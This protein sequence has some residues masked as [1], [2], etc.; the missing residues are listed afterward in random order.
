MK[1]VTEDFKK[2]S[3][4]KNKDC[5]NVTKLF[6]EDFIIPPEINLFV[7]IQQIN[8]SNNNLFS[9]DEIK[10]LKQLKILDLS[11]NN[12]SELSFVNDLTNLE[13][14]DIS[15]NKFYSIP[16]I[17]KCLKLMSLNISNNNISEFPD[18]MTNLDNLTDIYAYNLP[19]ITNFH[20]LDE[21]KNLQI[22]ITGDSEQNKL[23]PH[24]ILKHLMEYYDRFE[25]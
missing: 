13:I 4:E 10:N 2:W 17:S 19:K 23:L 14:L 9:I 3:N 25:L 20:I 12:L 8:F 22:V 16:N 1:W 15:N 11:H 6:I 21:L 18:F 7:N 24:K 5:E